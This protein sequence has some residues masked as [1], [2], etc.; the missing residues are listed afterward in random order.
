[1]AGVSSRRAADRASGRFVLRME[2]GLH[3]ALR[4]AARRARVSLNDYCVSRLA[5]A[6]AW[7]TGRGEDASSLVVR[8]AQL[9]GRRLVGVLAFGSWA[10]GEAADR[11][12]VDVLVVV[13]KGVGLDRNLYAKWDEAPVRWNGRPADPHFV[14]LPEPGE[15]VG[16]VWA[17]AALDGVVLFERG[18]ELS[19][20]LVSVRHDI[21]EG[22]LVR[23]F[24]H[25]QP[26]WA[27][28][29]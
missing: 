5:S 26:Y 9:F 27:R 24:A 25:G 7:E 6:A 2:P 4:E 17:E 20:R 21:A 29:A 19:L 28:V 14:R 11:S 3:E 13:E 18:L 16:G 1:M 23:R 15:T 22:R 8:A 10:R 12:D